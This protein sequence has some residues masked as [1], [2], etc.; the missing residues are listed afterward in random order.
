M[1]L[2]WIAP[3]Y[4]LKPPLMH[5]RLSNDF[6][7]IHLL[8]CAHCSEHTNTQDDIHDVFASIAKEVIFM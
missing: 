6:L 1:N 5:L 2:S 4:N 7:G 8:H 3:S